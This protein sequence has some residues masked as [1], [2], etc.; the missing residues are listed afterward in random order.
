LDPWF[1][2]IIFWAF[3]YGLIKV[4]GQVFHILV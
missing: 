3:F 2:G 1:L 4:L